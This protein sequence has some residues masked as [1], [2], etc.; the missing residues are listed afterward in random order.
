MTENPAD[1][2]AKKR[3]RTP[4]EKTTVVPADNNCRRAER[5]RYYILKK[6]DINPVQ[7]V[8]NRY[9]MLSPG[10]PGGGKFNTMK[11]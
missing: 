5:R 3:V 9:H 4:H 2:A 11:G 10:L 8:N 1:R 7:S 6:A